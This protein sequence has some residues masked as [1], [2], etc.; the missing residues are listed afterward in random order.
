MLASSNTYTY[1]Y[2]LMLKYN[3]IYL[4]VALVVLHFFKVRN[5]TDSLIQTFRSCTCI[6]TDLLYVA[7]KYVLNSSVGSLCL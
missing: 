5:N 4:H 7:T 3:C 6:D 1:V 2:V